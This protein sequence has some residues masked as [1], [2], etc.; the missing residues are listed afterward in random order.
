M[1]TV[2]PFD[3]LMEHIL[4]LA[5]SAARKPLLIL[6]GG[7]SRVGKTVL[8]GKIQAALQQKDFSSLWLPLDS[9]LVDL[10]KRSSDSTVL[11]R[12]EGVAIVAAVKKIL[13]GEEIF[14]PV[15]D[16]VTRCRLSESGPV[17]FKMDSGFLLVDGVI[18]LA[19]KGL[20][21]LARLKIFVSVS[22]E[23]RRDRLSRFYGEYKGLKNEATSIIEAR[24]Q[25]EVPF[26][27][28]TQVSADIVFVG[29]NRK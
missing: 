15:Y 9:W 18:A 7:C 25:E 1:K 21:D 22:S 28:G 5:P 3:I 19:L 11:E 27:L 14:P 13:A 26:I 17:R 6:I 10:H 4:P 23:V 29:E 20:L 12:F 8:A 24:E 2:D 16:P